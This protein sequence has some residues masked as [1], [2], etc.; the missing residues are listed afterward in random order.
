M[1][2]LSGMMSPLEFATLKWFTRCV[3]DEE[4][5]IIT[6]SGVQHKYKKVGN[7]VVW[8]GVYDHGLPERT[9]RTLMPIAEELALLKFTGSATFK[10]VLLPKG[11]KYVITAEVQDWIFFKTL[12]VTGKNDQGKILIP[13]SIYL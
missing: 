4:I 2:Q 12:N 13:S 9:K 5:T 7:K 6:E 11:E 10:F 3:L 1:T 8:E